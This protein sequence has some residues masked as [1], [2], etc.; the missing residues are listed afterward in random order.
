MADP[1]ARAR[2]DYPTPDEIARRVAAGVS[3]NYR[4]DYTLQRNR[5]ANIPPEHNCSVW[6]TNLP[7]GVNHNQLL[8]AIRE[9]GRVWACVITPPSGRYTSAAAKVTFFTPAAAQTMLARCNEPGQPGLVVGNHRAAVRPDRNPV[10]EARDPEDHTRVLSIRGPKDLVNEAY[11]ANYFSRAFVYEI[12]EIIWL[13]EGEAINVLE[14]RFGSYRC[15]A[16]WAWRNIQEDAY[17]QQRGV[18]ITFQRD[19]CDISR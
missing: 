12:D 15:Q 6:I 4:G 14:W 19:P 3:P 11:L 13:V 10:A 18:V 2:R 8:G 17:L 9:T 1:Y 5:P 7:P 16:Q